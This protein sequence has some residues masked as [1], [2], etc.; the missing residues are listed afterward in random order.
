MD[1]KDFKAGQRVLIE[2]CLADIADKQHA[3]AVKRCFF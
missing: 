1:L 2:E 3:E